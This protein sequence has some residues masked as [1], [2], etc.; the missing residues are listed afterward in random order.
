[1]I[2]HYQAADGRVATHEQA[3]SH[4]APPPAEV[5]REDGTVARRLW[6]GAKPAATTAGWP[7]TCYASGVNAADAQKLRDEFK[8]VGVP[9]EVTRDG[10]PVYMSPEHRRKALRARGMFD[11]SSYC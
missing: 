2:Y 11:R 10:D 4:P 9:T 7:L 3:L 6:G 1:V 8:R 5:V